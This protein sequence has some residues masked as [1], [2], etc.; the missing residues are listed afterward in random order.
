MIR[1]GLLDPPE[2]VPYSK[3]KGTAAAWDNEDHKA[4]ARKVTQESIVLLKNYQNLLP[5]DKAKLK[6]VAVIGPYADQVALDWYSGTPPY[7]ISPLEGFKSKLG[8]QVRVDFVRDNTDDAAVKIARSADVAI[9][10]VGN[11][12]NLQCR[13]G[14]VSAAK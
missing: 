5:L 14:Q 12:P 8:S 11:H 3:I 2:M 6:S 4:L 9:V 1:L 13:M 7:A 10:V